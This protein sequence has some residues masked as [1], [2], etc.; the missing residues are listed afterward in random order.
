MGFHTAW[1]LTSLSNEKEQWNSTLAMLPGL[2]TS[3]LTISRPV[4]VANDGRPLLATLT[5]LEIV[6][7]DVINPGN[8]ANVEFHCSFSFDNDVK[9]HAVWKPIVYLGDRADY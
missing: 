4:R 1:G 8:I 9:P 3:V 6:N 2:M 7:T 5:G